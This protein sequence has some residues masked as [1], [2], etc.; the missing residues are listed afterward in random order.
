MAAI[1]V[2]LN[3]IDELDLNLSGTTTA[4]TAQGVTTINNSPA[5]ATTTTVGVVKPD[6]NTIQIAPDGTLTAAGAAPSFVQG[7]SAETPSSAMSV[8]LTGISLGNSL[9]LHVRCPNSSAPTV[10]TIGNS[11]VLTANAGSSFWGVYTYTYI[12]FGALSTTESITVSGL[13][14]AGQCILAEYTTIGGFAGFANN[15]VS[16]NAASFST[17][18]ITSSTSFCRALFFFSTGGFAAGISFNETVR[19]QQLLGGMSMTLMD[20]PVQV[21]GTTTTGTASGSFNQAS[22]TGVLLTSLGFVQ[23]VGLSMPSDFTVSGSPVNGTGVLAVTGGV[24]KSGVQQ[25]TYIYAADTGTANAYAV[26]LTPA[27]TIVSGSEVVFKVLNSNTGP[28]TLTVNGTS[29]PLK[30][31]GTNALTTGDIVAGQM[32]TAKY[33]GTNFQIS[34]GSATGATAAG[35]Q[36]ETYT[37]AADTGAAN[38][39]AVTLTPTPALVAG[40]EVTFKAA[41]ANTGASTLAVNGGSAIAITKNGNS[42]ALAGGDITVGQIVTVKYD[43]TVW[44]MIAPG[45]ATAG[46][47]TLNTLSGALTIAAGSNV[48][49][50]PSGGNTLTIASTGGGGSSAIASRT[51]YNSAARTTG[52]VYQNTSPF[53]LIMVGIDFTAGTTTPVTVLSDTVNPPVA[54]LWGQISFGGGNANPY[55]ALIM[56]GNFYKVTGSSAGGW[57][58]FLFNTGTFTASGDLVGSKALSTIYQNTGSGLRILQVVMSGTASGSTLS[59]IC[60]ANATPTTLVAEA[61]AGGSAN[62]TFVMIPAGYFYK[63]TASAGSIAHWNE[64]SSNV[65]VS[66]SLNLFAAGNYPTRAGIISGSSAPPTPVVANMSGKVKFLSVIFSDGT[67]GTTICNVDDNLPPRWTQWQQA[68]TG[69]FIRTALIVQMPLDFVQIRQDSGTISASTSWTEY[70]LG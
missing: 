16:A 44:Q 25:N 27:P 60:D 36:Q 56:P 49:V 24:T 29:Y 19:T 37:Y 32:V 7:A 20:T 28:S 17:L 63:V 50:T 38:A 70:T 64:F 26:T 47:T 53:P 40:S 21:S 13:T 43:G 58:E 22:M 12:C 35:V 14:G 55:I 11:Y 52:T 46:V 68:N 4:T 66:Q 8:G 9:I 5:I 54:Q 42:T 41:N 30:K 69:G 6:N 48:T 18:G 31:N 51:V 62:S 10:T 45:A 59:V 1:K 3:G 67:T 39:Y 61:T 23:S 2:N 65:A 15:G 33:D 34:A 57:Q